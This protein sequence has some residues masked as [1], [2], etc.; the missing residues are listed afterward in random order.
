MSDRCIPTHVMLLDAF[1]VIYC[2]IILHALL[3]F[4]VP[5]SNDH[6]HYAVACVGSYY[7]IQADVAPSALYIICG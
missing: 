2:F 5:W 4:I 6:T 7:I 1:V 3:F